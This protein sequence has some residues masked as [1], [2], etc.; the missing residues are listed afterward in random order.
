M[1]HACVLLKLSLRRCLLIIVQ[2]AYAPAQNALAAYSAY[3]TA[4]AASQ[5]G[6]WDQVERSCRAAIS[7]LH[8][9]VAFHALL[10]RALVELGQADDAATVTSEGLALSSSDYRLCAFPALLSLHQS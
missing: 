2:G 5:V 1:S 10:S 4:I 6:A 3:T 7:A 9:D 8:A